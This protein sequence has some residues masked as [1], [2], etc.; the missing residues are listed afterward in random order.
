MRHPGICGAWRMVAIAFATAVLCAAGTLPLNAQNSEIAAILPPAPISLLAHPVWSRPVDDDWA[1]PDIDQSVPPVLTSGTCSLANV[2]GRAGERIEELVGNLDRFTATEDVE[3]QRVKSKG[4]LARPETREFDYVVSI[5]PGSSSYLSVQELRKARRA[6]LSRFPDQVSTEGT[7]SLVLVFHPLYARDFD[8]KCEGLSS[9]RGRPAWQVRFEQRPD[10]RNH[11]S[12][13]VVKNK[14]YDVRIRGRAWILADS[15][16]VARLE[17]DLAQAIPSIRLRLEHIAVEYR[18]VQFLSRHIE[19]WL[20]YRA[21]LYLDF[22]GRRFYRRHQY[23]N[24]TLFS[25]DVKQQF[26]GIV[27]R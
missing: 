17:T 21:E 22:S 6:E 11:L 1:P 5:G 9:W 12:S 13:V 2:V 3:H 18:P 16:Q 26:A 23:S 10:R 7:P 27:Q 4:R 19:L 8:M 25:V 15:F 24:F 20:P 14:L